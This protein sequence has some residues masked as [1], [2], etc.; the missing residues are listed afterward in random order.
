MTVQ[1]NSS[2]VFFKDILKDQNKDI[3]SSQIEL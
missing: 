3:N 1:L 2:K